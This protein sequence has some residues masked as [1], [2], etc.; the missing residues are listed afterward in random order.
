[1]TGL[2]GLVQLR[3]EADLVIEIARTVVTLT[4]SG[5]Q[6]RLDVLSPSAVWAGLPRSALPATSGRF[7]TVRGIG[8]LADVLQLSGLELAVYGPS[9][10]L[11]RLGGG[12]PSRLGRLLTGSAAVTAGRPRVLSQL[13]WNLLRG[14]FAR[15]R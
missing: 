8:R 4:G 11:L 2:A 10:E 14:R 15:R 5:R 6:L 7:A 1:M 9:G 13:A 3:V 12:K